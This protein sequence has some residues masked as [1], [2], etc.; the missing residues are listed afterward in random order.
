M[1]AQ[2]HAVVTG[3]PDGP[4]VVLSNSLGSTHRMWDSQVAALEERFRVVRYDT[5]G[6]GDSPVPPGPYSIDELA[7]DVIALLDR[8]D[9]E[10]AHL[11][12]LSLGGMTMMRVAARNPERV[13]RLA[14]LC[15]AAYLPPAQGWTDRAALVRADGTSA[16]AAAVVQRWFTPGYLAANTEARQQFEAMVAATPAEGY[17]ACCEAIAAMDQRSDLS[18]I[19]APTLAIA[20]AGDPATPPDLLRDIVDAVPNGRLLVVPDSAHLANA[21]QADTI[22]PALIEHLEQQ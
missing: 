13:D 6:H 15:T 18:S 21:Q 12:G 14:L 17:A 9:I 2:V 22:T 1:S 4:A 5:R 11:V 20:G 16:V 7:D 19:I 10:R 8:F 3:R